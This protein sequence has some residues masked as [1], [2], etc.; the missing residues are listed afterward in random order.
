MNFKKFFLL[1]ISL[2]ISSLFS[3][4]LTLSIYSGLNYNSVFSTAIPHIKGVY[5]KDDYYSPLGLNLG[6]ILE[7]HSNRK[8]NWSIDARVTRDIFLYFPSSTFLDRSWIAFSSPGNELWRVYINP[9]INYTMSNQTFS[10][11]LGIK[12]SFGFLYPKY[13]EYGE[14]FFEKYFR[15]VH[16]LHIGLLAGVKIKI[17]KKSDILFMF[18]PDSGWA[19]RDCYGPLFSKKEYKS[20]QSLQISYAYKLFYKNK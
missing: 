8:I 18:I 19:I 17:S 14:T 6:L 12:N 10:F 15:D 3:Q 20:L 11:Y 4:S 16:K 5:I 7:N 2:K 13:G 1:I 9:T